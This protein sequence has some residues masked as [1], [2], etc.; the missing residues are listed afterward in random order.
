MKTGLCS[1]TFRQLERHRIVAL[2]QEA[3][4]DGI[5]WGGDIHVPPGDDAAAAEAQQLTI[6][7]GLEVSSYGSYYTVL[8]AEG[9]PVDF[10]PVLESALT[11]GTDT[12][13]IWAGCLGTADASASYAPTL[14]KKLSSDLERAQRAGVCV[15]LE[16]HRDTLCDGPLAARALLDELQHPNL[17]M[18]WQPMYW[19]CD[20][21]ACFQ[22]LEKMKNR[23]LN[24]HV[25]HW[26]FHDD[27][28]SWNAR[29]ERRPLWEGEG[30][31]R[32][33]LSVDLSPGPHYALLEFVRE[34][35]PE[36]FLEDATTLRGWVG[37]LK[38]RV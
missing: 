4:L 10:S 21:E 8:D 26:L 37:S 2:A 18:Y 12:V 33:Y 1:V 36:F 14:I 22:S 16:F 32:R 6:D 20:S 30:A 9:R 7:A 25:F 34:D 15:A 17:Y 3:V 5:E 35:Q 13:R 19:N 29:I 23:A 11:L 24:L 28:E 38:N 31:W 27:R